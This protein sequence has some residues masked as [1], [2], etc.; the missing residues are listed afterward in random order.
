MQRP[1]SNPLVLALLATVTLASCDNVH[2][3]RA[4]PRPDS[5]LELEPNDTPALA[6]FITV[7]DRWTLLT[8]E[9]YVQAV[10]FDVVDHLEFEASE[11][12]ELSFHLEAHAPF[13][14]VDVSIYDPIAGVVL[15]TYASGGPSEVGT[16]L[17]LEPGRPFQFVIDAFLVDTPWCLHLEG[18]PLPLGAEAPNEEEQLGEP[19]PAI[20]ELDRRD[21]RPDA[22]RLPFR[23]DAELSPRRDRAA[24]DSFSP[25]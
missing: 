22:A 24:E 23:T 20:D 5:F 14:D 16:L 12:M 19:A 4:V 7:T 21:E 17:V 9:G 2:V 1:R 25:Q 18:W 3:G 15:G 11:P 10:G 13:G 8:V 6:D